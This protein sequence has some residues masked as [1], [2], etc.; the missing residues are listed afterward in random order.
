MFRE[1]LKFLASG[2]F[3]FWNAVALLIIKAGL[4][5][6]GL[7]I[8]TITQQV[9]T[10]SGKEI[11]AESNL[12][13]KQFGLAELREDPTLNQAAQRKLQNMVEGQYFDHISPAGITPWH[14]ISVSGYDYYRAGE[15]LAL[16]FTGAADTIRA[17]IDSPSH[18]Q[19]LL[20]PDYKDIG[21]AAV[22]AKINGIDGVLVVQIFASPGPR[23]R[24]Q[25]Q[26]AVV[27]RPTLTPTPLTT[28]AAIA[29]TQSQDQINP[30]LKISDQ[31]VEVKSA[32]ESKSVA[33]AN[34]IMNAGFIFYSLVVFLGLL[35]LIIFSGSSRE[36]IVKTSF[37]GALSVLAITLPVINFSRIAF[38]F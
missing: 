1:R 7:Q 24:N 3:I 37:S 22:R 29:G 12:A 2:R 33:K 31:K 25:V 21:V 26:G 9:I 34:G 10:F 36:L 28:Q 23:P 38:I 5:Y 30:L 19:N 14:W 27:P 4:S 13:R 8:A 32:A 18:R 17:W 6:S 35:S 20:N 11:I 16:G 15:N